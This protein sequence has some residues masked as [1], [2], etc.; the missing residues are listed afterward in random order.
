M[1]IT[2]VSFFLRNIGL[3][4]GHSISRLIPGFPGAKHPD[5][6]IA[7]VEGQENSSW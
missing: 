1:E 4:P 3:F 7:S 6:F 5:P 2:R